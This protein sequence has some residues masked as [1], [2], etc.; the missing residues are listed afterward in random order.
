MFFLINMIVSVILAVVEAGLGIPPIVSGVYMLA[1]LLPSIALCIRRV[2]DTGRSGWWFL[3]N[4]IPLVGAIVWLVF[5]LQDSKTGD[6]QFGPNPKQ[7][8]VEA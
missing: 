4:F 7:G 5:S 6:N 3:I 8:A 1:I 2:H